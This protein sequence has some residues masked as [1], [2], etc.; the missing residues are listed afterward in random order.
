[1]TKW[2]PN[3]ACGI[4]MDPHTGEILALASLPNYDPNNPVVNDERQWKNLALAAQFEPGSTFKPF[5]VAWGL[6]NGIIQTESQFIVATVSTKWDLVFC[7][8]ITR[9]E[10]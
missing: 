9:S 7:E 1:M 10:I 2:N 3:G 8:T 4:V 5:V 6:Q